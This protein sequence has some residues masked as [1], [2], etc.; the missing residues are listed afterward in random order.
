M[1]T[2]KRLAIVTL[3][4]LAALAVAVGAGGA[5]AAGTSGD[6]GTAAH[7][8]AG[9]PYRSGEVIVGYQPGPLVQATTAVAGALGGGPGHPI[10][11]PPEQ[12]LRLPPGVSVSQEVGHLQGRPGI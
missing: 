10:A 9:L 11:A 7:S 6:P 5:A 4:A 3:G 2:F 8:A 12:E 1:L